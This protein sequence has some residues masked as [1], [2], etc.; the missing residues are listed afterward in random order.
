MA[1]D[2]SKVV[3]KN[4]L[5]GGST[6]VYDARPVSLDFSIAMA[7]QMSDEERDRRKAAFVSRVHSRHATEREFNR[8]LAEQTKDIVEA[9]DRHA[10]ALAVIERGRIMKEHANGGD[11]LYAEVERILASSVD[12]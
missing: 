9:Q 8:R 2:F 3:T 5:A 6:E 11:A 1:I 10:M 4:P 7:S 12:A